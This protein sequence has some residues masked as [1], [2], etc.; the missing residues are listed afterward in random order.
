MAKLVGIK[1]P[2]RFAE[3]RALVAKLIRVS[4]AANRETSRLIDSPI[5]KLKINRNN[6][7]RISRVPRDDIRSAKGLYPILETGP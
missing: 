2:G 6:I 5:A 1:A 3:E 7:W 4:P